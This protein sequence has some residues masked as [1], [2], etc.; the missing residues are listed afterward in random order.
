LA[1]GPAAPIIIRQ[2]NFEKG[3][4]MLITIVGLIVVAALIAFL[5]QNRRQAS[6]S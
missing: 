5:V 2:G 4:G 1:I 6:D 3:P